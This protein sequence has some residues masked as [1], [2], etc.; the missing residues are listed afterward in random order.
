MAVLPRFLKYGCIIL[1]ITNPKIAGFPPLWAPFPGFSLLFDNPGQSPSPL[2]EGLQKLDCPVKTN[3]CLK[4]YQALS[5]A[6][7]QLGREILFKDY[8]LCAMPEN[9]YHVTVWDGLNAGNAETV[10]PNHSAELQPFLKG[11]PAALLQDSTFISPAEESPL[12][13]KMARSITFKFRDLA[14]WGNT[15]LVAILMPVDGDSEQALE[16]IK[17][18]R[19][20]LSNDYHNRFGIKRN[21]DFYPHVT[22]GYFA[23]RDYTELA[24]PEVVHWNEVVHGMADGLTITFDS[25]SLY[26]FTDMVTFFRK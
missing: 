21:R 13:R 14:K 10:S 18:E 23:N 6:M 16:W 2:P 4:L 17:R 20:R 8:S 5:E 11:L 12:T 9:T 15:S 1:K 22:L 7:D 24:T 19:V 3:P 25:I 26:G